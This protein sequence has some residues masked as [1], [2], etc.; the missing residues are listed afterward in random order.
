MCSIGVFPPIFHKFHRKKIYVIRFFKEFRWRYIVIDDKLPFTFGEMLYSRCTNR[1]ELW[2]P[3]I[4]KAYAKLFG[5]YQALEI[6]NIDDA[7]ADMTGYVCEKRI[8]H[9]KL[10]DFI[11]EKEAFW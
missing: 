4:E 6:G 5:C 9:D 2:V 11:L 3:I 10:N 8:M 7:I 1:N